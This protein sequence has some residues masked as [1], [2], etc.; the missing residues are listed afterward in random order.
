MENK[1]R[2]KPD[3]SKERT[4]PGEESPNQKEDIVE[5]QKELSDEEYMEFK[6][7]LD[8]VSKLILQQARTD[9]RR[10][11]SFLFGPVEMIVNFTPR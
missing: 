1:R 2:T 4:A 7:K 6:R 9:Y 10:M 5:T 11:V 8:E 3:P